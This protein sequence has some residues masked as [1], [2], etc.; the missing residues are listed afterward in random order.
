MVTQRTT[1]VSATTGTLDAVETGDIYKFRKEGRHNNY[2]M[3][4]HTYNN[5][6]SGSYHLEVSPPDAN[7]FTQICNTD[8]STITWT[9][10]GVVFTF[11]PAAS[12]DVRF[13][14]T[15]RASGSVDYTIRAG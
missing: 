15:A 13:N 4:V 7:K 6:L 12:S 10:Q 1:N 2:Q 14:M 11:N 9:D 3:Q 8:G 5:S